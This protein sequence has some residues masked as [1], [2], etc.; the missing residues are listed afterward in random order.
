MLT[1][2]ETAN[3]LGVSSKRVRELIKS[4]RLHASQNSRT[5][6]WEVQ[7]RDLKKYINKGAKQQGA[8]RNVDKK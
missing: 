3:A 8:V 7:L 5:F 4:R 1:T 2:Q 6:K